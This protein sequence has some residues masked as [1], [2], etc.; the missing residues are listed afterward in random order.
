M[1]S[2]QETTKGIQFVIGRL[3]GETSTT[4]QSVLFDNEIWT[5][6]KAKSWLSDH[7]FKSSKVDETEAKLRYRQRDPSNFEEGSFRTISAGSKNALIVYPGVKKQQKKKLRGSEELM[8]EQHSQAREYFVDHHEGIRFRVGKR[9]DEKLFSIQSIDF[10]KDAWSLKDALRYLKDIGLWQNGFDEVGNSWQF[11]VAEEKFFEDGSFKMIEPDPDSM[12]EV[13]AISEPREIRFSL[14]DDESE[15]V[16]VYKDYDEDEDKNKSEEEEPELFEINDVEIFS[17]GTW[18]NDKYMRKDLDDIVYSFSRVGFRPPI[19]LGHKDKSGGPAFGW[20]KA[21][22]R[23][24]DKLV[25][26]FMDISKTMFDAIKGRKFDT[27]SSEI[28]WDLERNGKKFRRVLKAVAL[29]GAETPA[30]SGLAPL[31]SVVLSLPEDGFEGVY[32]YSIHPKEWN[33]DQIE[34][35]TDKVEALEKGLEEANVAKEAAEAERDDFKAGK[36][37]KA[38]LEESEEKLK[39][40]AEAAEKLQEELDDAKSSLTEAEEELEKAKGSNVTEVES[41]KETV[42]ELTKALATMTDQQRIARIEEKVEDCGLPAI[43][44][45]VRALYDIASTSERTVTF[46]EG[47]EEGEDKKERKLS[48]EEVVDELVS[49]ISKQSEKLFAQLGVS[50]LDD[51]EEGNVAAAGGDVTMVLDEKAKKHM[52]DNKEATYVQAVEAVLGKDP[53]LRRQYATFTNASSVKA[54]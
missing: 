52:S 13:A 41:L 34:E 4:V 17:T 45:Y 15:I 19:K 10:S 2:F 14:D 7:D 43:R 23:K 1:K 42:A 8:E 30:V 51:R 20:V 16:K 40:A 38:K 24:G 18:N 31:R 46:S 36:K 6:S 9:H 5:S 26:D 44:P 54:N 28:F 37:K 35:L 3:K 27:V 47:G 48:A 21:L 50:G 49:M 32:S 12:M 53:D 11:E 39:E 33:M 29:L 25:A 22:R